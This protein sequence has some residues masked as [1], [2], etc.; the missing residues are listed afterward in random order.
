[1]LSLLLGEKNSNDSLPYCVVKN[2][3]KENE[4]RERGRKE[5]N[6]AGRKERKKGGRK[7]KRRE[8]KDF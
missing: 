5:G 8:T 7:E 6:E 3:M 1:M 4:K 2:R